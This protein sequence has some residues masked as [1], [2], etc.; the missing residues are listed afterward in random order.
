MAD[1]AIDGAA[2][3]WTGRLEMKALP[4]QDYGKLS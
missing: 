2:V 4:W 1:H 3:G